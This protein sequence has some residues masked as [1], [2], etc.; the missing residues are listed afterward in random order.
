MSINKPRVRGP[1][2]ELFDIEAAREGDFKAATT[3]K[4]SPTTEEELV[5]DCKYD[6]DSV[7]GVSDHYV[8]K[9]LEGLPFADELPDSGPI[10]DPTSIR[11]YVPEKLSHPRLVRRPPTSGV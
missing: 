1:A 2:V 6:P 4:V 3:L 9:W 11:E 10:P 8:W 5:R 7:W